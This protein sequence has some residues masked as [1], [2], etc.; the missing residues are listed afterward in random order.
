MRTLDSIFT[1]LQ[2]IDIAS[3]FD[4]PQASIDRATDL[5]YNSMVNALISK[6]GESYDKYN[7]ILGDSFKENYT[8][9][10]WYELETRGKQIIKVNKVY[11]NVDFTGTINI[12]IKNELGEETLFPSTVVAG[13]TSELEINYS[14]KKLRISINESVPCRTIYTSGVSGLLVDYSVVCDYDS[15]I[16][17]N[18]LRFQNCMDYKVASIILTDGVFAGEVNQRIMQRDDYDA[19]KKEYE[20]EYERELDKLDLKGSG[21]FECGSTIKIKSWIG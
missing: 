7:V 4:D 15:Y 5:A 14:G 13:I 3:M 1:P 9:N 19:L 20:I 18:K 10:N 17:S 12:K 11:I 8:S 6:E 2:N 16:C 21:C